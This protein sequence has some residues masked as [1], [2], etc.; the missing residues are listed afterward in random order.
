MLS[1]LCHPIFPYVRSSARGPHDNH[2]PSFHNLPLA[3][4]GLGSREPSSSNI[5]QSSFLLITNGG[6]IFTDAQKLFKSMKS[7][8]TVHPPGVIGS[9]SWVILLLI[10]MSGLLSNFFHKLGIVDNHENNMSF[11]FKSSPLR[12]CIICFKS[13]WMKMKPVSESVEFERAIPGQ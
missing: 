13:Y 8:D 6:R 2:R 12:K 10:T 9:Q 1:N 3:H 4:H 7:S 5:A 11:G